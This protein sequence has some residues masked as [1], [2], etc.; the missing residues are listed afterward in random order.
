[1]AGGQPSADMMGASLVAALAGTDQPRTVFQE[2]SFE[3]NHEMRGAVDARCH[4]IYN[5]SPETSWEVYRVDRDP[6]ETEDVSGDTDECSDTRRAFE[7]W[8]DAGTV[9]AGAAE[10]LLP[11]RP[12][13]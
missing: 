7:R 2:L 13:I 5:V 8:Y 9:P 3:G 12:A 6:L 10:A 11:S 1:L 4:V